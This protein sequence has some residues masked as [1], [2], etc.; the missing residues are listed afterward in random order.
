MAFNEMYGPC[1]SSPLDTPQKLL[2]HWPR[3]DALD[4]G[5]RDRQ[6]EFEA[7][8]LRYAETFVS[9]AKNGLCRNPVWASGFA[10]S[11]SPF[12]AGLPM[13]ELL[14]ALD[15]P[16]SYL[17]AALGPKSPALPNARTR[18]AEVDAFI[19][20]N[21]LLTDETTRRLLLVLCTLFVKPPVRLPE[22]YVNVLRAPTSLSAAK[23]V[24][25]WPEG[26]ALMLDWRSAPDAPL[27]CEPLVNASDAPRA[28]T[29][30][31]VLHSA[32]ETATIGLPAHGSLW[33]LLAGDAPMGVMPCLSVPQGLN[34]VRQFGGICPTT[35]RPSL[36]RSNGMVE[37]GDPRLQSFFP[38]QAEFSGLFCVGLAFVAIREGG[39]VVTN[40]PAL[41][42]DNR[43]LLALHIDAQTPGSERLD[44]LL[45]TGDGLA[46]WSSEDDALH[47]SESELA[48]LAREMLNALDAPTGGDC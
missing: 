36:L 29:L 45:A 46:V 33:V 31:V 34:A 1:D 35:R 21:G 5:R 4:P 3:L 9:F 39:G 16:L 48:H 6:A 20:H 47:A 38:G 17:K 15:E 37:M 2:G 25:G 32:S 43:R 26:D 8:Q 14:A 19:H 10:K 42:E 11:A 40:L 22:S 27:R 23:G 24:L 13:I 44:A 30:H 18:L 41:Y 12:D 7:M 28:L